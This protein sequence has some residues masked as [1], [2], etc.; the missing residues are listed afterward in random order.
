ML[1]S[2]CAAVAKPC[3]SSAQDLADRAGIEVP[4]SHV[5][6][7][8]R[9]ANRS[10]ACSIELLVATEPESLVGDRCVVRGQQHFLRE[11][12]SGVRQKADPH[13]FIAIST[14]TGKCAG[15]VFS[16]DYVLASGGTPPESIGVVI[17]AIDELRCVEIRLQGRFVVQV[18]QQYSNLWPWLAV[19][20]S[21]DSDCV[22]A[23]FGL[24]PNGKI[25]DLVVTDLL[26]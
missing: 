14:N 12:E 15:Y 20:C 24:N 23:R 2:N 9:A 10:G 5:A 11:D 25:R 22:S 1:L 7:V 21:E 17:D 4:Y 26:D 3:T 18:V 8:H 19:L 13:A 16:N 6:V